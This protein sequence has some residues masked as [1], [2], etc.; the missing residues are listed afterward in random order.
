M[1]YG[2]ITPELEKARDEYET[3]FGY[4]PNGEME[5]EFGE[6]NDYLSVLLKCIEEKRDMFEVL[7]E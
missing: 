1:Y 2:E 4:D 7:G 5:L 6:H 3:I